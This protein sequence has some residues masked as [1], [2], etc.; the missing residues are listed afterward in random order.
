MSILKALNCGA[1]IALLASVCVAVS[2]AQ[3]EK[4]KIKTTN[5]LNASSFK[6]GCEKAA[7]CIGTGTANGGYRGQFFHED[8]STT[9]VHCG[10]SSCSY[11]NTPP[12]Y[13]M[14]SGNGSPARVAPSGPKS[15]AALLGNEEGKSVR[16]GVVPKGP[17]LDTVYAP[18]NPKPPK[19]D[20]VKPARIDVPKRST[21]VDK[22]DA[23]SK[24]LRSLTSR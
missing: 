7:N 17:K 23:A 5:Q 12:A 21:Q 10:Q 19:I 11:H 6:S 2:P 14:P 16:P 3:A 24:D 4:I 9:T 18:G 13:P 1:A 8:G 20:P 22:V 15:L